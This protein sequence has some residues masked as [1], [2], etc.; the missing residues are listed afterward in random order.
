MS[1]PDN[2]NNGVSNAATNSARS[3]TGNKSSVNVQ[4]I[5]SSIRTI[6][7]TKELEQKVEKLIPGQKADALPGLNA[8]RIIAQQSLSAASAVANSGSPRDENKDPGSI[9]NKSGQAAAD[10]ATKAAAD[11]LK[12]QDGTKQPGSSQ[13]TDKSDQVTIGS[14]GSTTTD[15]NRG[16][17][18]IGDLFTDQAPYP[19]DNGELNAPRIKSIAGEIAGKDVLALLRELTSYD[20][21]PSGWDDADSPPY[22]PGYENYQQ[23]IYWSVSNPRAT[24]GVTPDAAIQE[25]IDIFIAEDPDPWPAGNGDVYWDNLHVTATDIN[26]N[27]TEYGFTW[28]DH[29]GGSPNNITVPGTDCGMEVS[30]RCPVDAPR[31]TE[32]PLGETI[33][34]GWSNGKWGFHLYDSEGSAIL[35]GTGSSTLMMTDDGKG[36][37]LGP[38]RNGGWYAAPTYVMPG[39]TPAILIRPN[40]TV[41]GYIDKN[42]LPYYTGAHTQDQ[43][44][45]GFIGVPHL[46]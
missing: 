11:A 25:S 35:N 18:R 9:I 27:P 3:T 8:E 16:I 29:I 22:E 7:K 43:N 23:G 5:I 39:T 31:V 17:Y 10:A 24:T 13:S 41:S 15:T 21:I 6:A 42:V 28:Y 1:I 44:D 46:I 38:L 37:E 33:G 34:F 26:G 40:G 2:N 32:F 30:G 45:N 4:S 36:Y 14:D 20:N 12:N 19:T